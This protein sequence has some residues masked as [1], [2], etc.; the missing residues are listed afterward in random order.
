MPEAFRRFAG[1]GVFKLDVT[2]TPLTDDLH[3]PET[4]IKRAQELAARAFGADKT[5][6]LVNGSTC[7]IQTMIISTAREGEKIL[8]SR[9][10]HRSVMDGLIL[11]GARPVYAVPETLDFPG[12]PGGMAPVT[13]ERMLDIHPDCRG[14]FLVSPSYYGICCDLGAISK[15]TWE[16]Q[17]PLLVDEA[18]GAHFYFHPDFPPGALTLGADCVVQ[19]MHKVGNSLTQSS[20]LH[21]R[22]SLLN[23]DRVRQALRLTQSTSPSYILMASLDLARQDL[24]LRGR[25]L[26]DRSLETSDWIRRG[27]AGIEGLSCVDRDVAGTHAVFAL[28]RTRLVINFD[29]IKITGFQARQRLWEEYRI[30]V[31]M[32]DQRN[33]VLN[34]TFGNTPEEAQALVAALKDLSQK[35]GPSRDKGGFK[36]VFPELPPQAMTPRQAWLTTPE[37]VPWSEAKGRIAGEMAAPYP[38]GIPLIYPGEIITQEIWE[39]LEDCR[40]GNRHLNGPSDPRL[41]SF[42][43]LPEGD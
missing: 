31:E 23:P 9:N 26:L 38:P 28:D 6:F 34:I 21:L 35:A 13:V 11:S 10:A 43:V 8:V 1:D 4:V 32:A 5:F 40:T 17:V 16:R 12:I 20:L 30:D 7:G 25:D 36:A 22:T 24:A 41:T 39:Y 37:K 42:L 33:L 14:V 15:I 2:E 3:N 18:H 19:S 29:R 27:I